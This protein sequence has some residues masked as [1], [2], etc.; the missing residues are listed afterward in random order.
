MKKTLLVIITAV[1]LTYAALNYHFIL[2]DRSIKILKKVDLT[3]NYTFVDARGA[4]K[5]K[6]FMNPS[7]RKAGIRDLFKDSSVTIGK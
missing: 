5:Y 2:M 7:L 1:A 6:L 3:F 4:K